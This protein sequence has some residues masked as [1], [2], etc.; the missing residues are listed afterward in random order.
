MQILFLFFVQVTYGCLDSI[1]SQHCF[2]LK[3]ILPKYNEDL[4]F[5]YIV[6]DNYNLKIYR[7]MMS[8]TKK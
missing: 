2:I 8:R 5:L 6:K 4:R 7:I 1:L 3:S